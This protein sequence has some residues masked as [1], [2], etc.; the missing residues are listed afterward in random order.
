MET[1]A[2]LHQGE[3]VIKFKADTSEAEEAIAAIKP[4]LYTIRLAALDRALSLRDGVP[5]PYLVVARAAQFE[6]YLTSGA[7]TDK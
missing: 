2:K 4:S 3:Y 1:P 6:D 5:S 7:K